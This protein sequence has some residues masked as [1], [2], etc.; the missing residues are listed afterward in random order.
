M[1]SLVKDVI[2]MLKGA[3]QNQCGVAIQ[4]IIRTTDHTHHVIVTVEE[5]N[6]AMHNCGP[7]IVRRTEEG[8]FLVYSEDNKI[9][10]VTAEDLEIAYNRYVKKIK[11]KRRKNLRDGVQATKNKSP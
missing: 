3:H 4:N 11:L 5:L 8:P 10:A 9:D 6:E 2:G 7:M 1:N